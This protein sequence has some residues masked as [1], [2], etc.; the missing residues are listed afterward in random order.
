MWLLCSFLCFFLI[1]S[2]IADTCRN[3]TLV[4]HSGY[5][6][7]DSFFNAKTAIV[8]EFSV[9]CDQPVKEYPLYWE[10]EG[11][12]HLAAQLPTGLH[13]QITFVNDHKKI[14]RGQ[15]DIRIFDEEGFAALR[16]KVYTCEKKPFSFVVPIL[17]RFITKKRLFPAIIY[18]IRKKSMKHLECFDI[19]LNSDTNQIFAGTVFSGHLVIALTVPIRIGQLVVAFTGEMRTKWVDKVSENIFDSV[20][21]IVNF[22]TQMYLNERGT[23]DPVEPGNY[24]LPF[25]FT[26]PLHLPSSFQAE[27]GFIRYVCF[28]TATI[29]PGQT[30]S[31]AT[32]KQCKEF[33][34]EKEIDIVDVV[35]F[36]DLRHV[37][38]QRPVQAEECFELIGCCRKQGRIEALIRLDEGVF[39]VGDTILAKLEIQN[40]SRRRPLRRCSL[41]LLQEAL[42]HAQS[43]HGTT[44]SNRT[45]VKVLDVASLQLPHPGDRVSQN[46]ELHIP[47]NTQP[48][49]LDAPLIRL[50]MV[51]TSKEQATLFADSTPPPIASLKS[52]TC[53]AIAIKFVSINFGNDCSFG[54][55]FSLKCQKPSLNIV[56][57]L[58][59][60]LW[61]W[62]KEAVNEL[63]AWLEKIASLFVD[64]AFE[65]VSGYLMQFIGKIHWRRGC[66]EVDEVRTVEAI[67]NTDEICPRFAFQLFCAYA[68]VEK[69]ELISVYYLRQLEFTLPSHPLYHF[70]FYVIFKQWNVFNELAITTRML[71]SN[72]FTWAMYHGFVELTEFLWCRMNQSQLEMSCVIHWNRFCKN[73]TNGR[74]FA[75]LCNKLCQ[76]NENSICRMTIACFFRTV[77]RRGFREGSS[78][79][80]FLLI[81]GCAILKARLF[82]AKGFEVLR[83]VVKHF[84]FRLYRILEL[85]ISP[86]QL[87]KAV[88]TLRPH[89]TKEEFNFF[90]SAQRRHQFT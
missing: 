15:Y 72:V 55:N 39:L 21:P 25:Q 37:G 61:N 33:K 3:P 78:L 10:Y 38:R 35:R 88:R 41:F 48:S 43:F 64:L 85:S 19:I 71:V 8:I 11:D 51:L 65:D 28:A 56:V 69:F 7:T 82:E 24:S 23:D 81:N 32:T 9:N 79:L 67:I 74:V 12:V 77:Q 22:K 89:F 49:S 6:T 76:R 80:A 17:Q 70:W 59:D 47:Q 5:S 52:L 57:A 83:S 26:L 68:M 34:V 31:M 58:E 84:D 73:A 50:S 16:K 46:V 62:I 18:K 45:L 87:E 29:L 86:D 75:Y 36:Q 53:R 4:K 30:C 42:F 2:S 14:G 13:Y 20:E 27:F 60:D 1:S 40:C 54:K 90:R 66:I 63:Q 44:S